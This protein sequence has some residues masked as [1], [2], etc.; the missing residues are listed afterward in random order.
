MPILLQGIN[1]DLIYLF[2]IKLNQYEKNYFKCDST[3][4]ADPNTI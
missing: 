4:T 1:N 2:K 3:H